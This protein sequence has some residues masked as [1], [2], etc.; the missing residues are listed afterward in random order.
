MPLGSDCSMSDMWDKNSQQDTVSDLCQRGM[1]KMCTGFA[2][3]VF[4][5]NGIRLG[6]PNEICGYVDHW[7]A[8]L[9]LRKERK[10]LEEELCSPDFMLLAS[11]RETSDSDS[12]LPMSEIDCQTP[13]PSPPRYQLCLLVQCI[14][15]LATAQIL[16]CF[17]A[18]LLSSYGMVEVG[19]ASSRWSVAQPDGRCVCLC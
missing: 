15:L 4:G 12:D 6:V 3:S 8:F 17:Y 5:E 19:T 18:S 13:T 7:C 11:L 9:D 14:V 16:Q 2:W 1:V 10:Y